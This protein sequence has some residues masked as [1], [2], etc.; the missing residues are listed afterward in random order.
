[1]VKDTPARR[2]ARELKEKA[3]SLSREA[4]TL[5]GIEGAEALAEKKA[6]EVKEL[7]D[8]A[9]RLGDLARLEDLSVRQ[10]HYWKDTKEGKKDYPRWVATWREGVKVR[11]V[12]LGSCRKMSEEEAREKAR[13]LKTEALGISHIQEK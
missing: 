2:K 9:R 13:R 5:K 12:Y 4:S 11:N 10:D 1:M 3:S 7:R 8:K 6:S